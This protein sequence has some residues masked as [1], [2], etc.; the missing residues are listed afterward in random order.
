MQR[1]GRSFPIDIFSRTE[2]AQIRSESDDPLA[3]APDAAC[4][5]YDLANRNKY[6][7][8]IWALVTDSPIIDVDSGLLGDSAILGL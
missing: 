2:S 3:K 4:S 6:C 7:R 8:G 1:Q 5:N